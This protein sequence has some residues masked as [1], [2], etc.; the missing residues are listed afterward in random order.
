MK[1]MIPIVLLLTIFTGCTNSA[2][3][4][5]YS[6][7]SPQQPML[8][9]LNNIY[10]NGL[11]YNDG[12]TAYFLSF[13]EMQGVPLCNKPNCSH[14]NSNCIS[15]LVNN[16]TTTTPPIIYHDS[17]YYFSYTDKIVDSEDGKN[18]EYEIESALNKADLHTGEVKKI[19][20]F[21]DMEASSDDVLILLDNTIYFI[22][23]NGSIQSDDGT[24]DYYTTAGKQYLCAVDLQTET[25]QNF[26]QI[27][28]DNKVE[29]TLFSMDGA[30][31]GINGNIR[32]D[33]FHDNKIYM[34]YYYVENQEELFDY[35][36]ENNIFPDSDDS[37]WGRVNVI[38]DLNSKN[39][40]TE[41][42]NEV[43]TANENYFVYWNGE[44]YIEEQKDA[45][46]EI[47]IA[48]Q[49]KANIYD[50]MIWFID[51][52]LAYTEIY[53]LS[54]NEVY[55]IAEE[56]KSKDFYVSAKV[57]QDYIIQV[58]DENGAVTF[59]RVSEDKLLKIKE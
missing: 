55:D 17:V 34:H 50:N 52:N 27:N 18:T 54:N 51:K 20:A 9:T 59:Q 56:Y 4:T 43:I 22:A 12:S 57:G 1:K 38:F 58:S 10:C 40:T 42:T 24:W 16:E 47:N 13:D 45:T 31:Y 25:F 2:T 46:K 30:S 32:I 3:R 26:G 19:C 6:I 15:K 5:D 36:K 53:N 33:G 44:K 8:S 41:N 37:S 21:S 7:K 29:S 28:D 35:F 48:K 49:W 23:N 39:F 14:D 11:V